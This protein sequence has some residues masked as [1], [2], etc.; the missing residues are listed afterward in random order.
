MLISV[1]SWAELAFYGLNQLKDFFRHPYAMHVLYL[2]CTQLSLTGAVA[3]TKQWGDLIGV[4]LSEAH[5]SESN[6]EFFI[7][8]SV[9][10]PHTCE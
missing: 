2:S 3:A 4:S 6:G 9:S 7:G 10:E 8:A 1:S 5:T